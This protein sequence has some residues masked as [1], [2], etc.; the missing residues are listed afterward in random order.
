MTTSTGSSTRS[1]LTEQRLDAAGDTVLP[2][3]APPSAPRQPAIRDMSSDSTDARKASLRA[4]HGTSGDERAP[5]GLPHRSQGDGGVTA[6]RNQRTPDSATTRTTPSSVNLTSAVSLARPVTV[7]PPSGRAPLS[8]PTP[9]TPSTPSTP[10]TPST[11]S[12]RP[13]LI[14]ATQTELK[15]LLAT[16]DTK[17]L[18]NMTHLSRSNDADEQNQAKLA[19]DLKMSLKGY[20]PEVQEFEQSVNALQ[21]QINTLPRAEHQA[22]AGALATI[23]VAFR[24]SKDADGRRRADEQLSQLSDALLDRATIAENDP[25][26]RALGVFNRPVGAGYLTG[27]GDQQQL[28]ALGRLRAGFVAAATPA[29]RERYFSLA[30]ELKN[31]L[32]HKVGTAID[33]HTTQEASKWAAANGE[34]NRIIH[35]ADMLTND[36]GKRY[37][38]IGRQLY[39]T[40]P[41]S[42]R[43]ELADRR[44]LAFT[45]RMRD[46]PSLHGKL[47]NWSVEAGRKLNAHGVDAQ[48]NYL[49]ILNNLPPAGPD[50]VRDLADRY[51]AVLHDTSYKDYSVTPRVRAEK[52]AEQVFEGATRFLLGLTPFAPVTAALDPHSSLSPNTRLGIDLA[53]GLL[54][55]LAG[56][57]EA[58]F[59][60]RLAAKEAGAVFKAASGEHLPERPITTGDKGAPLPAAPAIQS[61]QAGVQSTRPAA[62]AAAQGLSVDV[63]VAEA[64]QRISGTKASLPDSYA[65][66]PEA[67]SLKAAMGWKNVLID[68][69][70]QHYISSGGK[71]YPARFDM[72]NNTWRVYQPE[73][74]YRPQ[75]PVR[76]NAQGDWEVHSDVGLKGGMDP[77]PLPPPGVQQAQP[78]EQTFRVST[79]TGT[80]P[81]ANMLQTLNPASWHSEANGWLDNPAF[82]H[83][84][85]T[86]FDHLPAN[87]QQALRNWTYLDISETY[88]TDS[89]YDDVNYELNQQLR[90]RSYESDTATRAQALQTALGR[91][92]RPEGDSRLLR[93]AEVPADYARQFKAGDYVTNSPAFMSA[94]SDNEYA[95]ANLADNDYVADPQGAFALYDIQSKSATPFIHRVTTLAP[96]EHEWLFRP[97]TVFRVDE[98]ATA[99]SQDGTQTPRIGIRLTEVPI[100][101]ATFAKNIYTGKEELVY[102]PGTTPA[103]TTLQPTRVPPAPPTQPNPHEPAPPT[104]G[105]PNQPGPSKP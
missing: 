83:P 75:Y 87:Q 46:D 14:G 9:S 24:D 70:G 8:A 93:I 15:Q 39:S 66:Q 30:A 3:D 43:D 12:A 31:D 18:S 88:S 4:W 57:G 89:D 2:P 80:P 58:A 6:D 49:D 100:N 25:V 5:P 101:E 32:Q 59:G 65:V 94:A 71:T 85:Q 20:P 76:L 21:A 99:T 27:L 54:G 56:G 48:K 104:H 81:S 38:L 82:T 77:N 78:F 74:A 73:N 23:D 91:L 33:Q 60:E 34:V 97:N 22:Y 95:R 92:P 7:E 17:T 35:E 11:P 50:Y 36:P 26:E 44:L 105:D 1:A 103:Y 84:Y 68:N 72:D 53:S 86:A 19:T 45:Q 79:A 102:P 90:D 37:E 63:A 47:V 64:S 40:N 69:N 61:G 52:L 62:H 29:A 42:G 96:G 16:Y 98:I 51:N 13:L 55:F 10:P 67:D 28:S 41:G